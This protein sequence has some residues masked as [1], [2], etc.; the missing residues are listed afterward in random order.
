MTRPSDRV[1][2]RST[3]PHTPHT[4]GRPRRHG[5]EFAFGVPATWGQPDVAIDA[6]TRLYGPAIVRAW[7]RLHPRLT[8]RT[9]WTTHVGPLPILEGTVVRL[10]VD[11]LPSGAIPKPVWL[12][13]S[14]VDLDIGAV[15][16]LWQAFLRRFDIEHTFRLF[17]QT[18]GWTRPK[19]RTP[20]QADRWGWLVLAAYTQLGSAQASV[21]S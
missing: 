19:L 14:R 16:L 6:D 9:A 21:D 3:P 13:H 7:N 12:W 10:Q 20:E 15:D 5:S 8:H 18:L 1:L 11:R 2:R 17:K 4:V